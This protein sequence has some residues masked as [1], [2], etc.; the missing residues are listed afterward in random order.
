M[1]RRLLGLGV[2]L[3]CFNEENAIITKLVADLMKEGA[4]VIVVDDGSLKP[5]KKSIKLGANRGYG[6]AL[7]TGIANLKSDIVAT[8]DGDGQH[9]IGELVKLYKAW[10]LMQPIDMIVGMRRLPC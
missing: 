1:S 10:K 5:H 3:P 4:E 7:M 8:I 2:T 9:S 6:V